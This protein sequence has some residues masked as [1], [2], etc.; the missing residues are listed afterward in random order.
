GRRP[1]TSRRRTWCGRSTVSGSR[2][3]QTCRPWSRPACGWPGGSAGPRPRASCAP[4]PASPVTRDLRLGLQVRQDR[5]DGLVLALLGQ[6]LGQHLLDV[7]E[8]RQAG[9]LGRGRTLAAGQLV[10]VGPD[11]LVGRRLH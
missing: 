7:L 6:L 4:S 3:G 11:L 9:L 10:V 8:R 5:G 1:A 2:T